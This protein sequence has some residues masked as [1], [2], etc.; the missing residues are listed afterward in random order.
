MLCMGLP[1]WIMQ[2]GFLGTLAPTRAGEISSLGIS[3]LICGSS[4]TW[5]SASIA[6][7]LI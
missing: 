7:L 1:I 6:G 2:V 3:A 5:I 4:S